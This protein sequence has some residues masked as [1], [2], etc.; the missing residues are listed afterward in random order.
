[1]IHQINMYFN[2]LGV[3]WHRLQVELVGN[4]SYKTK[5]IRLVE[6]VDRGDEEGSSLIFPEILLPNILFCDRKAS[7]IK[8]VGELD[9]LRSVSVYFLVGCGCGG[10][11]V[12][13]DAN[14]Q[15]IEV[16]P[17]SL[18][19]VKRNVSLWKLRRLFDL[20]FINYYINNLYNKVGTLVRF[21]QRF[22]SDFTLFS[23]PNALDDFDPKIDKS[24]FVKNN[25]PKVLYLTNS[26]P[27]FKQ[28]G[29]TIRTNNLVRETQKNDVTVDVCTRLGY[30][31]D[32]T[33]K[34]VSIK[35]YMYNDV[36]YLKL[37]D[38]SCHR[39]N[40]DLLAYLKKYICKVI[41]LVIV[42]NINIV[43]ASSDYLNGVVALYVGRYVG[44]KSIYELRGFWSE[45]IVSFKPWLY[46]SDMLSMRHNMEIF[47]SN[48]VDQLVT[49]NK[50]LSDKLKQYVDEDVVV[51]I[52]YNGADVARFC[53]G[54]S[55]D[56]VGDVVGDAVSDAVGDVV[57]DNYDLV[58]GYIG[59]ILDYEGLEYIIKS[60]A[61]LKDYNIK[62]IICGVGSDVKKL[63]A[64]ASDLGVSDKVNYLGKIKYSDVVK[65]YDIFDC[66]IYPRKNLQVCRTTSSS[67]VFEAMAMSKAIIVS[68]L[69]AWKEIITN[70]VTGLFVKP[71]DV[72]DLVDK[73]SLLIGDK[74]MITRLG[75]A[76]REWIINNRTWSNSGQQ[77]SSIYHKMCKKN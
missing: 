40:T 21:K 69:E 11:T 57:G 47:V 76:A 8:S 52:I 1:M 12:S 51:E 73:I 62:F 5:F 49:I 24:N 77:L 58:I 16:V 18:E 22:L 43:H 27:E 41:K 36:T 37:F 67:K 10:L 4:E 46:K 38:G 48:N 70:N 61:L 13:T 50:G 14:Y 31:L 2:D 72:N 35:K 56:V 42:N 53:G 26:S 23:V 30:P 54:G 64:L 20:T 34:T 45:S 59:S 55:G 65:H 33:T 63:L 28:I 68:D 32:I 15:S 25:L 74:K 60:I 71:D 6:G 19:V 39:N 17:V 7:S 44:V 3:G 29:Y 75:K 9:E 66:V